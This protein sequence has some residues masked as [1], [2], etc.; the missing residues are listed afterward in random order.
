MISLVT[1]IENYMFELDI[2]IQINDRILVSV[3][4]YN[5]K[6]IIIYDELMKTG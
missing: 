3:R 6:S 1:K 2:F 5:N 4:D